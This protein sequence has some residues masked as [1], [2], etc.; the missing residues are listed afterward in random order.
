M[1]SKHKPKPRYE[2]V[3]LAKKHKM[4]ILYLPVAHPEL[5]PIE[6]IWSMMKDYIKKRNVN[7]SLTDVEKFANEFFDTYDESE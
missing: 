2:V 4:K 5:N 7:Y 6:M 1:C 3:E